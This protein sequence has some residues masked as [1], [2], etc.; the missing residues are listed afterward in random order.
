MKDFFVE[1]GKSLKQ[2]FAVLISEIKRFFK[3]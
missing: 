2:L 3:K 1:I